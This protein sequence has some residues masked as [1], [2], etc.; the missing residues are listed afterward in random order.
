MT[1]AVSSRAACGSALLLVAAL[2]HPSSVLAAGTSDVEEIRAL[3]HEYASAIA[4]KDVDRIMRVYVPD[5]NLFVFE[6]VPPRQFVGAKAYRRHVEGFATSFPGPITYEVTDVAV[7]RQG[8]IA[9]GHSI[10][11][12]TGTDREGHRVD[13]TFRVTDVYRRVRGHWLIVQEHASFPV[14]PISGR[15][16]FSST[17]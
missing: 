11:H 8:A 3:E 9:W 6:A 4:S 7:A 1:A 16:D 14:D 12:L 5:E 13:M 2:S 15:A 17:P 10:Q